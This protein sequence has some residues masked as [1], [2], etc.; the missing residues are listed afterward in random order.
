LKT[1]FLTSIVF[2][3]FVLCSYA[4]EFPQ[5]DGEIIS[6]I[7]IGFA[8]EAL[9]NI[10]C[11]GVAKAAV[12]FERGLT[13]TQ[14]MRSK[15]ES[16]LTTRGYKIIANSDSGIV[17][18]VKVTDASVTVVKEGDNLGRT[19]RARVHV[20]LKDSTGRIFYADSRE[21]VKE[22]VFPERFIKQNDDSGYYFRNVN[23]TVP[24][25]SYNKLRIVSFSVIISTLFWFAL[26]V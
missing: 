3:F 16:L 15:V 5:T 19:V 26:S 25:G 14:T 18:S 7:V 12:V 10:V 17:L 13:P 11:P 20:G 4:D 22:D 6:G 1:F 8:A 24:E 21:I 23:V 9:D 2:G